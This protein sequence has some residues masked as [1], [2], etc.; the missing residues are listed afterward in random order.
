MNFCGM[1]QQPNDSHRDFTSCFQTLMFFEPSTLFII[2]ENM[3]VI[4]ILIGY[5]RKEEFQHV[6]KYECI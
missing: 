1:T 4:K 5:F 6:K 3:C 2:T